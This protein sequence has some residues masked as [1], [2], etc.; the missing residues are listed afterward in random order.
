MK[1]RVL[2]VLL[3]LTLASC[4]ARRTGFETMPMVPTENLQLHNQLPKAQNGCGWV[5]V[6]DIKTKKL[7]GLTLSRNVRHFERALFYCCPGDTGPD[8]K[9]YQAD[10]YYRDDK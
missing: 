9:C 3:C 5:V 4:T 8:P 10:W 7:F 2:T 1:T 6:K